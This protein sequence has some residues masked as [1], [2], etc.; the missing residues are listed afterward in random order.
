VSGKE[1]IVFLDRA[2]FIA[3]EPVPWLF[4][5]TTPITHACPIDAD[6]IGQLYKLTRIVVTRPAIVDADADRAGAAASTNSLKPIRESGR[7][8]IHGQVC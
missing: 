8:G 3:D 5:A 7:S 1:R 6:A 2:A 4:W